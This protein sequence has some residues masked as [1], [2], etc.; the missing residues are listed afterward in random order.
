MFEPILSS[1]RRP[2]ARP[3]VRLALLGLALG[4]M[5]LSP[6]AAA[7]GQE[8]KVNGEVFAGEELEEYLRLLQAA[9]KSAAYP[10]SVRGLSSAEVHRLAPRDTV[11]PWSGRYDFRQD[12]SRAV[13]LQLHAPRTRA[14]F[15]SAFPY[16]GNDG[17]VWAGRGLTTA[18]QA[19]LTARW[20]QLSLTLAPVLF[21]AEN[22]SFPL[23]PHFLSDSAALLDWRRPGQIDLPQRYGEGAYGRIDPGQSTLRADLGPFTAGLSTANQSW[24][25]ASE[26]PL[27]L[28]NNAAGFLHAFAGTSRPMNLRIGRGH[29][30]FVWGRL[31]TS[32]YFTLP[33]DSSDRFMSG[34]IAV[35]SPAGIPGLEIGGSR[36]FHLPWPSQGIR[37][38]HLLKPVE[39][40]VKVDLFGADSLEIPESVVANQLASLFAR[41]SFPGSGLELY[42]ELASDDHRHNLRDALVEPDHST[43]YTLGFRK[44]WLRDAGTDLW[45]F[46]GEVLNAEPSHLHRGRRQDPFYVHAGTRQGHTHL[47][48]ILG[49]REAYGGSGSTLA[50]DRY[51]RDG[52]WTVT[53]KRTLRQE[54][55][56]FLRTGLAEEPD[57]MQSLRGELLLFRGRWELAGGVETVYNFNRNF[58]S[59]VLNL[60]GSLGARVRL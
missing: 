34:L 58:E 12:T 27:I 42:G 47:G 14:I 43:I 35:F 22:R 7:Q 10:W 56:T 15:N 55:G 53:W 33:S 26:Y 24:G 39:T 46:R 23:V 13:E 31:E 60:H 49:S 5:A 59:D 9:G 21:R 19:G 51:T 30:R 32:E 6:R 25:P 29:G 57:V 48:Q 3:R 2:G 4:A 41:W 54:E 11:H 38:R 8:A 52:R 37:P 45:A 17:A 44:V 28:G 16:G 50:V 40:F 20:R 1:V 36:F 18:V